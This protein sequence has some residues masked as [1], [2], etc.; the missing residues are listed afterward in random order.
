MIDF[1]NKIVELGNCATVPLWQVST[2]M[3]VI[4]VQSY[5]NQSLIFFFVLLNMRFTVSK[6]FWQAVLSR[7]WTPEPI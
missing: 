2:I 6:D 7:F 3:L 5:A 1:F 4:Q